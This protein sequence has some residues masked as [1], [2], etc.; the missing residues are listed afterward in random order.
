MDKG[1]IYRKTAKGLEAIA[2]RDRALQPRQRSLLILVDGRRTADEL[3]R[4]SPAGFEESLG[5]LLELGMVEAAGVVA[6]ASTEAH[7]SAPA[8]LNPE[9]RGATVPLPEAQRF[10]VRRLSDM[11]GPASDDFCLR[12]ERTRSA[13][14]FQA[15]LQ[16]AM[17]FVE[18]NLGAGRAREFAHAME[19]HRPS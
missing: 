2:S 4:M 5:Q 12:I 18:A 14:E 17:L 11:L 9:P 3:S 19:E 7:V 1:S 6:D 15:V 16:K 13:T 10:A 8:P